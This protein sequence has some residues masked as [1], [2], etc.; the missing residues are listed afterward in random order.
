MVIG[1]NQLVAPGHVKQLVDLPGIHQ[2]VT[3]HDGFVLRDRHRDIIVM[4]HLYQTAPLDMEET[5]IAQRFADMWIV[6]R[7]T[8]LHSVLPRRLEGTLRRLA[9]GQQTAHG[10]DRQHTDGQTEQTR[11]GS[12]QD[13]HGLARFLLVESANDEVRW[14]TDKGTNTTHARSIT[15]WY[16]QFGG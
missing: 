15:Q 3:A 5:G 2:M 16:K 4:I 1:A 10:N 11:D 13:V 9:V 14:C 12:G 7:Y 8:Q 6:R